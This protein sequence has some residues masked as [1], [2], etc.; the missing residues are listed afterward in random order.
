VLPVRRH[1]GRLFGFRALDRR[2]IQRLEDCFPE[3][4]IQRGIRERAP[5]GEGSRS[6]LDL[7]FMHDRQRADD[8]VGCFLGVLL[9][10]LRGRVGRDRSRRQ[11]SYGRLYRVRPVFGNRSSRSR[12][13]R[14]GPGSCILS[15]GGFRTRDFLH[16]LGILAFAREDRLDFGNGFP[17]L[18]QAFGDAPEIGHVVLVAFQEFVAVGRRK[19]VGDSA[20]ELRPPLFVEFAQFQQTRH[21]RLGGV[22]VGDD[23]SLFGREDRFP[24][25]HPRLCPIRHGG[26]RRSDR[27]LRRVDQQGRGN[28]VARVAGDF[29]RICL[30]GDFEDVH[31][32]SFRVGLNGFDPSDSDS[33]HRIGPE[34]T[35]AILN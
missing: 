30:H 15:A 2:S 25:H 29:A 17:S 5:F 23:D 18:G 9:V 33:E 28:R 4:L 32:N 27:R 21:L 3:F 34:E 22:F 1:L 12:L 20:D 6:R 10:P 11:V 26:Q 24:E 16:L 7:A 31:G 14:F 13:G 35:R 19:G 8:F